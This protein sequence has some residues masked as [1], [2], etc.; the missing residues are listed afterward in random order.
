MPLFGLK[1]G[2][3]PQPVYTVA[4]PPK[5]PKEIG[6]QKINFE[7][8]GL[9]EYNNKYA[10]V[11]DNLFTLEDCKKLYSVIGGSYDDFSGDWE[12]AQLNAG[13]DKQYLDT[14]YRNSGRIM[15]D[16]NE[17]ADWILQKIYP[18]LKDIHLLSDCSRHFIPIE[19]KRMAKAK[20]VQLNERLRFL[21]Y[22]PG[23]FFKVSVHLNPSFKTKQTL[24]RHCDG[25]YYTPDRKRVSYYTLQIYLSGDSEGLKGGSTR[26]FSR[27]DAWDLGNNA[28]LKGP[29]L[30]IPSRVGRVL[31]FEQANLLHSGEPIKKGI[32]VSMR[33]DFMYEVV[34]DDTDGKKEDDDAMEVD[35]GR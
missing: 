27:K 2:T 24:Q 34:Y 6:V 13:G 25:M 16:T 15:V 18:Y 23:S 26:I 29:C 20:L 32:K 33:T 30:D 17:I 7:S 28:P 12:V 19:E 3:P 1:F 31:V 4:E 10:L 35:S 22:E 8:Y 21:R 11:L 5:D 9:P 14:S